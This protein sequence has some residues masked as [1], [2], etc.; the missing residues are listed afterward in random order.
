MWTR[1][2]WKTFVWWPS[3][4]YLRKDRHILI[5]ASCSVREVK[6]LHSRWLH[7]GKSSNNMSKLLIGFPYCLNFKK[8]TNKIMT[9]TQYILNYINPS[10]Y[11]TG[12]FKMIV[13]VLATCHTQYTWDRSMCVF[14][15]LIE[16]HKHCPLQSSPLYWLY[17]VPNVTSTV[18]MLPG[19]H[20]LW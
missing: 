14:F 7:C 11:Y 1:R 3:I 10:S 13:G 5:G 16:Q 12:L 18:G 15:Y 6:W 20:F 2:T 9:I 17:T 19:T 4:C 8:S